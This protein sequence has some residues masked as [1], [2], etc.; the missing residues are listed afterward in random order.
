MKTVL[1]T[2]ATGFVGQRLHPVLVAAGYDVLCGSRNPDKAAKRFPQRSWLQLNVDDP[3][4]VESAL[5]GVDGAIFLVHGLASGTGYEERERVAAETFANL[6]AQ[7]GVQRVVYLGGVEPM[8]VPSKHLES[9]LAT[10]RILR[11]GKVPAIELRAGMII[12]HGSE[13]WQICRDLA[14]R[15]PFMLLPKWLDTVSEPVA[16]QDVL[17]ACCHA[18][19]S[20]VVAGAYDLPGPEQL[21]AKDIL[22]RVA[23]LR[24]TA[25]RTLRVPVLTPQLSSYW[26]KLVTGAD[27]QVAQQLVEGLTAELTSTGPRY[28]EHMSDFEVTPFDEAA[29]RALDAGRPSSRRVQVLERIMGLLA[30]KYG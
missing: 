21:S 26:L 2:G 25:T 6:C 9:R 11:A 8:G 29:L 23:R 27:F 16:I 5:K 15:L 24:G 13:S 10:G 18:L 14:V 12:G 22:L 3:A 17:A 1:L 7:A 28:W 30:K 20:D 19:G 4:S